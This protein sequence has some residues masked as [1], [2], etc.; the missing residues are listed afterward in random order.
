MRRSIIGIS[1]I[2]LTVLSVSITSCKDGDNGSTSVSGNTGFKI[3]YI[4]RDSLAEQYEFYNDMQTSFM[5]E[6]QEKEG[7]LSS[8]YKALQTRYLKIQRDLQ[9]RMIT[10][11]SAEQK[12]QQL[13]LDQQKWQQDQ[14]RYSLE[15]AEKSQK[16]TLQILDSIK[17]Y[18]D[19]YNKDHNYNMI[20]NND[21]LGSIVIYA[22]E[23]M[24]I[25]DDI[26]KGLNK[27]YR[28]SLNKPVD[29]PEESDEKTDE[30]K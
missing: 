16:M 24:N 4:N 2:V 27:R 9:N 22:D 30:S 13:G 1:L 5:L 29:S 19:I 18:V 8:R 7:E 20:L 17:N 26:V 11:T 14:E 21:T 10:P 25:T 6:Q 12:N 15:M 3:A 23:M 28:E